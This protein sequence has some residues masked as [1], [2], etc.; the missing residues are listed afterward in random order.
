MTS[1][2]SSEKNG[3]V[4]AD[5]GAIFSLAVID[6][7]EILNA[8]F[9]DISIPNAVW[10]EITL[11]KTTDYYP[12]IYRFFRD[13]IKPIKGLNTLTPLM[14]YGESE[15]VLLYKESAADFLLIDGR[16]A[17]A[18]AENFGINC[19]GTL[20]ILSV[21]RDKN[22][23]PALKPLFEMLLANK[24]FYSIKLLNSLLA[25]HDEDMMT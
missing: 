2:N 19:I 18:I 20:G 15:C 25:Q 14:D 5:S 12:R 4:I 6:Q 3:L 22:L 9:D 23:I 17:R 11:D 10:H 13:K 16:K 24:R 21:A 7:L 1:R 8:L